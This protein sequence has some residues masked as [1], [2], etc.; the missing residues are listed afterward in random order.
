MLRCWKGLLGLALLFFM[1]SLV[2]GCGQKGPL[3]LPKEK[4]I[5]QKAA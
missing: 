3:Y 2:V 5:M 1:G 4:E